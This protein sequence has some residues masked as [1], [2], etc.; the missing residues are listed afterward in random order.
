M[1]N[2]I[3]AFLATILAI[4]ICNLGSYAITPEE[5][6][7]GLSDAGINDTCIPKEV[8]G[9]HF[10]KIIG[11]LGEDAAI[12]K[13]CPENSTQCTITDEKNCE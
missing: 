10:V 1:L 5:Y 13:E 3:K 8:E 7:K 9:R 2:V 12:C 6:C 11:N 4:S